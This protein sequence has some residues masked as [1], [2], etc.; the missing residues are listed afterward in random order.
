MQA[1]RLT[2][3]EQK[4]EPASAPTEHPAPA[5]VTSTKSEEELRLAKVAMTK[6]EPEPIALSTPDEEMVATSP[7]VL[8]QVKGAAETV[9]PL[10]HS[11]VAENWITAPTGIVGF[12][13]VTLTA[14]T[15]PPP[16]TGHDSPVAPLLEE[17]VVAPEEVEELLA[18]VPLL[19]LP[20][21]PAELRVLV[22]LELLVPEVDAPEVDAPEVDAPEVDALEVDATVDPVLDEDVVAELTVLDEAVAPV[23]PVLRELPPA[24]LELPALAVELTSRPPPSGNPGTGCRPI[25]WVQPTPRQAIATTTVRCLMLR[26]MPLPSPI[27]VPIRGPAATQYAVPLAQILGRRCPARVR[28]PDEPGWTIQC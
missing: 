11:S 19:E 13:G 16:A 8:C 23:E 20:E 26:F 24:V 22:V 28:A 17:A 5:G 15:V 25:S 1:T 9:G 3:C 27:R 2:Y 14:V 12:W 7:S 10:E 6:V 18:P 4:S 21:V